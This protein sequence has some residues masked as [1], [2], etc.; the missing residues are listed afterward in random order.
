MYDPLALDLLR[1]EQERLRRRTE[2]APVR[3]TPESADHQPT[4]R[5]LRALRR[6]HRRPAAAC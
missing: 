5:H 3:P 1:M 2:T 6:S 4:G